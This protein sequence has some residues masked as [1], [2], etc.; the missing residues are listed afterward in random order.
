MT[1]MDPP[2]PPR[3]GFDPPMA[4]SV[5]SDILMGSHRGFRYGRRALNLLPSSP[6]CK[7]CASPFAPPFGPLM[8]L[9]GKAPW[10]KNPKYCSQCYRYLLAHRGG[11]EIESSFLFAD[12]RG[13]TTIAES[14]RPAEFRSLMDRFF[15]VAAR[16]LVAHDAIVDKFVGDEVI[17]IFVPGMAGPKHAAR[18]IDAGRDLLRAMAEREPGIPVG[19]GVHTGVAYVGT[20]GEGAHVDMTAMGD[21][22]NVTARLASAANA[23]ELLVTLAAAAAAGIEPAGLERRSLDL[24]G[25]SEATEV[26]VLG[27]A[28]RA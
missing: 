20:V 22:V 15:D 12:V 2:E 21:P 25:K 10:P 28:V 18:A 13:S 9:V 8:R 14:L 1:R 17:G 11:A 4:D 16:V 26:L 23:G 6:R 19:A 24:K 3:P 5:A 27:P 7:Q